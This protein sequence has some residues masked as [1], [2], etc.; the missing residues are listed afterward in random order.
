M[1]Y[2]HYCFSIL[3]HAVAVTVKYLLCFITDQNTSET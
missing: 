3:K 2:I 1:R